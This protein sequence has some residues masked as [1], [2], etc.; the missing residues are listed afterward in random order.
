M[1]NHSKKV[2]VQSMNGRVARGSGWRKRGGSMS[3]KSVEPKR[4][5]QKSLTARPWRRKK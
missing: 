3:A 1:P 4:H 5:Q 2:K